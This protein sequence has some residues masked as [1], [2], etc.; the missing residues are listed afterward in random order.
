MKY[1][2][3]YKKK[4]DKFNAELAAA[5]ARI[6][7]SDDPNFEFYEAVDTSTQRITPIEITYE[8]DMKV[9]FEDKDG[10]RWQI[11]NYEDYDED[12]CEKWNECDDLDRD[13]AYLRRCI[14]KT[15]RVWEAEDSDKAEAEDENGEADNE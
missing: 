6:G 10:G 1:T 3:K 7:V 12:D 9:I 5:K 13:I 2:D 14:K 8:D 11:T 4:V 15:I